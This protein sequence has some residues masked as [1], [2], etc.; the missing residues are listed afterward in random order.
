MNYQTLQKLLKELDDVAAKYGQG[1][2]HFIAGDKIELT[3]EAKKKE[4]EV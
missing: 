3:I 4:A 2:T 1:I